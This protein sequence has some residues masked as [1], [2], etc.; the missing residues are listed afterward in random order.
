MKL[1]QEGFSYRGL[2]LG[3]QTNQGSTSKLLGEDDD[4]P[5]DIRMFNNMLLVQVIF[6]KKQFF[7]KLVLIHSV[8]FEN[9]KQITCMQVDD[10]GTIENCQRKC[11]LTTKKENSQR[12]VV[13]KS[14]RTI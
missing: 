7:D 11:T 12:K 14:R 8:P 9:E 3:G 2:L 6:L 4:I 1:L 13:I 5:W 10:S